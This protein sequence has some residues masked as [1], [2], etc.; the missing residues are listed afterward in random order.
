MRRP[1]LGDGRSGPGF[2]HVRTDEMK[3]TVAARNPQPVVSKKG[4]SQARR[5]NGGGRDV[6][7]RPAALRVLSAVLPDPCPVNRYPSH[8]ALTGR[9]IPT[10]DRNG[11]P[12][13][14]APLTRSRFG[15]HERALLPGRASPSADR[16]PPARRSPGRLRAPPGAARLKPRSASPLN[17]GT[18][19]VRESLE[20][21]VHREEAAIAQRAMP[22]HPA[23]N[24]YET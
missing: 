20:R 5:Q 24:L 13:P 2:H 19:R 15:V 4:A 14:R 3:M 16:A 12:V 6:R 23:G 10:A 9:H 22:S 17:T 7:P 1:L 8:P 21:A 11:I 18:T